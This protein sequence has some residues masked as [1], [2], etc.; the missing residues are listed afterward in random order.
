MVNF[1]LTGIIYFIISVALARYFGKEQYGI[2][3]YF[4]WF[5]SIGAILGSFGLNQTMAKYLPDYFFSE[6]KKPQTY[7]LFQ[8]LF[9]AQIISGLLTMIIFLMFT[10]FLRFVTNFSEI[11]AG[12]MFFIAA[13][14]IVPFTINN[15]CASAISALQQFKKLAFIQTGIAFI[16]LVVITFFIH[17]HGDITILFWLV[18][19]MNLLFTIPFL[20]TLKTALKRPAG[21][22]KRGKF[23]A[24][25]LLQYSLWSYVMIIFSQ[26]AWDRSEIFF[27]GKFSNASQI[28]IYS[29]AYSMA[30]L[31]VSFFATGS[32]VLNYT[33]AEIVAHHKEQTLKYISR[34]VCKYMAIL[35]FPA[36]IY[37]AMFMKHIV[38]FFYGETFALSAMLF[39]LIAISH[40]IAIIT[41]PAANVPMYKNEIHKLTLITI[42]AGILNI[43]LDFLIIPSFQ[44][45]GAAVANTLAQFFF[46][47][48]VLWNARKYK[49]GIFNRYMLRIIGI[50]VILAILMMVF[51]FYSD[52][53]YTKILFVSITIF[54]YGILMIRF[55][56]NPTDLILLQKL[57]AFMPKWFQPA[58]L[59]VF[60]RIEKN[61]HK[62][63]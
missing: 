42:T 36:I 31:A 16:S 28:A 51:G 32:N 3:A 4:M 63:E 61:V 37:A 14:S 49:L 57:G 58:F 41:S 34:H 46:I 53:L 22:Y 20:I 21:A 24:K 29:L 12:K 9:A 55:V 38:T 8:I 30:I 43:F 18:L 39:P 25:K 35:M 52:L 5:I 17:G 15:L 44:A 7:G 40:L 26:I 27:L 13:L 45:L 47:G 2:Y 23:S 62:T 19:G 54:I 1:I 50:N 10:D 60:N 6:S 56:F 48:M 11:L 59:F 33:T